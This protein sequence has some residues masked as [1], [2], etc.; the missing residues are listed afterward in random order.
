MIRVDAV[1][2]RFEGRT[3]LAGVTVRFERGKVASIVG[4][5][6]GGKSTLLRC[7]NGL[8][9]FDAGRI[10]VAGLTLGPSTKA[11]PDRA[12]LAGDAVGDGALLP[13]RA[14]DRAEVE[15]QVDDA[16]RQL[17]LLHGGHPTSRRRRGHNRCQTPVSVNP[18]AVPT[19]CRFV[20]RRDRSPHAGPASL[21]LA[22]LLVP[23]PPRSCD[24]AGA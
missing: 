7:I 19:S 22:A 14:R 11:R 16:R 1:E 18:C 4:P 2:K 10:E 15:E 5:S 13:R 23:P 9:R 8:E 20:H 12:E 24:R 21:R 17:R 3:V 6:G